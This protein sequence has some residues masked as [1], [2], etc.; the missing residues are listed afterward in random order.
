MD[1]A[2]QRGKFMKPC[3]FIRDYL[4]LLRR[5]GP[6]AFAQYASFP[7]LIGVGIRGIPDDMKKSQDRETMY[8]SDSE[9]NSL[10]SAEVLVGRVWRIKKAEIGPS[11][12]PIFLGRTRQNDVHVGEY[13]ISER[14]CALHRIGEGIHIEDL[15]SLNGIHL[16]KA[17]LQANTPTLIPNQSDV[18]IGRFQFG[19]MDTNGFRNMIADRL[20][21]LGF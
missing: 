8:L 20:K 16:N 14:H 13:S 15:Q 1:W 17:R 21:S 19:Y 5:K 6:E 2:S 12:D 7:V 4:M 3:S 11:T 18:L 10:Q 9:E